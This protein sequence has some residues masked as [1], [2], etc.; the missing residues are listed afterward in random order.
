MGDVYKAE[1]TKLHRTVAL[2]FLPPQLT[3]DKNAQQRFVHE[4][5]AASVLD[6]PNIG[7]IYEIDEVEGDS[8]IAMAYHEGETLKDRIAH[9]PLEVKE[10]MGIAIQIAQGLAVAHS[11]DIIHRDIKPANIIITEEGQVKIIDFGLAKLKGL[12]VLTKT[13][14]TMG[15]VA[16]MSPEQTRGGMVDHRSDI[17]ALGVILYEMLAGENPFKGE[18]EQAVMYM[19]L[20]EQPE[21]VTKIRGEVPVQIEQII[22]KSL[23]KNPEKR[24]QTMNEML[25]ELRDAAG[26]LR[27]D[28][29]KALPLFKLG[30]K[31]RRLVYRIVSI[32]I[33]VIVFGIYLWFSRSAEKRPV[34]IALLPLVSIS[35]NAEQQEWITDGMTDALITNMA[36]I[37]GIRVIS[38]S[39]VM[40]YKGTS[41]SVPEI[42][43]E[44][45]ADYVVDGSVSKKGDQIKISARL[46]DAPKDE[47]IWADDYERAFSNILSLQAEIART[48]AGKIQIQLTPEEQTRLNSTRPVNPEA[49]EAYLK[50]MFHAYKLSPRD[51]ETALRYFE[52]ALE[53]DPNCALGYAGIAL[54]W[55][56]QMQ[57]GFMPY[58][59]AGPRVGAAAAKALELDSTLLEI[60]YMLGLIRTWYDWDWEGAET[61]FRRAISLNP[62]Y[63]DARAYFSQFLY[64]TGRPEEGKVQIERAL[65]LDPLSSLFQA[66]YGMDL[67]YA[68]RYDDA[69]ATLRNA[70]KIAPDDPVV[71][72]T[73]RTALHMKGMYK[74]ALE[75]W[76]AFYAAKG[77]RVAE[78]VLARGYSKDGYFARDAFCGGDDG[79]T[80]THHLCYAMANWDT[81]Y[82]GGKERQSP[83]LA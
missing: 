19:I 68:H 48:I 79:K 12:T 34:S 59:E 16:Y 64:I 60:H 49:Y 45:G 36:K 4:A 63:P 37:S 26:E 15:T 31:Q 78:E 54:V 29:H 53:K 83:G 38:R 46:I 17:W 58:S 67:L 27:E 61:A 51:L 82:P 11:K 40:R 69:V 81:L 5:R 56:G 3:R 71:R 80:V 77:D 42:A 20:N 14:T 73:L 22:E 72:S 39:S 1:D 33:V 25:E 50:G 75:E 57:M 28:E 43:R 9:G 66:L 62:N 55:G 2:K 13:G 32:V 23:L 76:K 35:E 74:E 8:F 65:E 6:H 21:F 41:K 24:F 30:R 44:L 7:T 47:Y 10:A 18:Y 52:L 70:L